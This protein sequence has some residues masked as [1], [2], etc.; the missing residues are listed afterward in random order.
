MDV[1]ANG[2]W[3]NFPLPGCHTLKE[4]EKNG[5]L[6]TKC[7]T[8]WEYP[9]NDDNRILMLAI[10]NYFGE[11]YYIFSTMNN[12]LTPPTLK[13]T[14]SRDLTKMMLIGSTL[15]IISRFIVHKRHYLLKDYLKI[16]ALGSLFGMAYSPI[17]LSAKIDEHRLSEYLKR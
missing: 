11:V 10:D 6:S 7:L 17:F 3:K 16:S 4:K 1:E 15:A 5:S 9:D 2:C 13:S 12:P 8:S 14:L